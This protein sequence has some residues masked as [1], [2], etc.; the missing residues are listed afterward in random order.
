MADVVDH[1]VRSL[2]TLNLARRQLHFSTNLMLFYLAKLIVAIIFPTRHV[3][4]TVPAKPFC[5][6][7]GFVLKD[8]KSFLDPY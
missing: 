1:N 6:F 7:V 8:V 5:L 2:L 3:L 4:A